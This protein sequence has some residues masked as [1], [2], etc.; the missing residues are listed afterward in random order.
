MQLGLILVIIKIRVW[1]KI[2]LDKAG[3]G[4]KYK[5]NGLAG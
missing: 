1:Y 4:L 5:I 2:C 3:V